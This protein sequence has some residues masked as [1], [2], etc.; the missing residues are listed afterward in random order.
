VFIANADEDGGGADI[1]GGVACAGAGP[2]EI[3]SYTTQSL[4]PEAKDLWP[5]GK[6]RGALVL[7]DTVC[8]WYGEKCLRFPTFV[9]KKIVRR[10]ETMRT[11]MIAA[12]RRIRAYRD[13]LEPRLEEILGSGGI[14]TSE[15]HRLA[16]QYILVPLHDESQLAHQLIDATRA[17]PASHS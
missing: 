16:A 17:N 3:E 7:L 4:I 14:H 9:S 5:E 13:A 10:M 8:R 15:L 2:E 6:F 1:T 11:D 12:L